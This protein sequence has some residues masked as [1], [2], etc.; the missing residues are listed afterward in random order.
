MLK[1]KIASIFS[2]PR[3]AAYV[4]ATIK[5]ETGE[6]SEKSF[7]RREY[8]GKNPD[9]YFHK[10]YDPGSPDPA[11]SALAKKMGALPG[12]GIIFYGRGPVQ[13]TWRANY[14]K[15]VTVV[16]VD[17]V[18]NPDLALIPEYGIKIIVEGMSRGLFTG[19]KLSDYFNDEKC[20]WINARRI[21]NGTDCAEKIAAI[22]KTYYAELSA[23]VK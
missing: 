20:D 6:I 19:G 17:L 18:S 5:H 1:Q 3:H 14:K 11:R 10:M 22:A 9:I 21:V 16:G 13:L 7:S 23:G 15:F 12:D 4:M 8:G 2:D